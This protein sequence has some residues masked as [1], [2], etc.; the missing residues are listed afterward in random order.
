MSYNRNTDSTETEF[1][2]YL[3]GFITNR[4]D[5]RDHI[6]PV[7]NT[8]L[9]GP[10]MNIHMDTTEPATT[11][12]VNQLHLQNIYNLNDVIYYYN[13]NMLEYQKNMSH[14]LQSLNLIQENISPFYNHGSPNHP[15]NEPPSVRNSPRNTSR[16]L[17]NRT[18]TRNPTINPIRPPTTTSNRSSANANTNNIRART[19]YY[20]MI[21]NRQNRE[22]Y[23]SFFSFI[24]LTTNT[25]SS[26]SRNTRLT[27]AQIQHSTE[28]VQ[29]ENTMN[30]TRCPISFEDFSVGENITRIKYCGH[31]FKTNGLLVWLNR[32]TCC[33]VCRYNLCDYIGS[34]Q[35]DTSIENPQSD[36]EI[37]LEPVEM[38]DT[39]D[40]D[41]TVTE[42]EMPQP[43]GNTYERR[44]D[45][46]THFLESIIQNL[47]NSLSTSFD[48]SNNQIIAEYSVD[49]L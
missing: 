23:P 45:N 7:A 37:D 5:E 12:S 27:V 19:N 21:R 26:S 8:E 49:I 24:P 40:Q 47:D 41:E 17:P 32:S 38:I 11:T 30:E 1:M 42:N 6:H 44:R 16:T 43:E 14:I 48:F 29:Y 2:N 46:L 10:N 28:T 39:E 4:Q 33:P 13:K 20:S 3:N 15:T 34:E 25:T 31:Y 35:N 22:Q 18:Q 36:E 9:P